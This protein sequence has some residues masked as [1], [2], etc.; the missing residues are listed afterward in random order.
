[1]IEVTILKDNHYRGLNISGHANMADS[2]E[3]IVCAGVSTLSYTLL[4]YLLNIDNEIEFTL[5]E[6]DSPLIDLKLDDV[7]YNHQTIQ[8][9]F[10]FFDIGIQLL[11]Q[12]HS[13]YVHLTYQEV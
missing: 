2:G 5:L 11:V 3:D 12:E 9:G 4:N 1:M 13:D 10:K 6:G 7:N 8:N